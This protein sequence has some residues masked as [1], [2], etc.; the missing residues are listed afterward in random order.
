L[1]HLK[2]QSKKKNRRD[3]DRI[4]ARLRELAVSEGTPLPPVITLNHPQ[5]YDVWVL[6]RATDRR[7]LPSQLLQE[8]DALLMDMITLDGAYEAVKEATKKED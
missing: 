8:N 1:K 4:Y 6:W 2:R 5:A 3:T 7:F